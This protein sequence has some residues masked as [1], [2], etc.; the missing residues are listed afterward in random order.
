MVLLK[1]YVC[2]YKRIK[3]Q[4]MTQDR[5]FFFYPFLALGG[6]GASGCQRQCCW[7][8]APQ[9]QEVLGQ[10]TGGLALA[11]LRRNLLSQYLTDDSYVLQKIR[12]KSGF[13]ISSRKYMIN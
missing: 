9:L 7:S 11:A 5:S 10:L 13:L 12:V 3:E 2:E 4:Y 1:H 8:S 6:L